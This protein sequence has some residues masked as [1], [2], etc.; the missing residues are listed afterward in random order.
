MTYATDELN[1]LFSELETPDIDAIALPSS[2]LQEAAN[3]SAQVTERSQQWQAYLNALAL[4]G[5]EAWLEERASDVQLDRADASIFAPTQAGAIA[6]TLGITVNQ[7]RVCLIPIDSEPSNF[8]SLDRII[9]ETAE[10]VPHFYVLVEINEEQEQV[11]ITGWLRADLLLARQSELRLG[12]DWKYDVPLAWFDDDCDNLLLYWRCASPSAIALP[13]PATETNRDRL[14]WLQLLAQ[15][16]INTAQWL[17]EEWQAIV[18]DLTWVLLPPVASTSG[19]RSSGISGAIPVPNNNRSPF[20]ELETILTA[21]ERTGIRLPS[22]A[23][24]AYQDFDLGEYPLRLYAVIGSEREND[25]AI[26]WSLLAILGKAT[27]RALPADLILRISDLTGVLVERQLEAQGA[28]LFAQVEG[29]PEERFLVTAS[30]A[31]GTERSLP[32][33]SFQAE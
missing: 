4:F 12:I 15:P 5:F 20:A 16:A 11:I 19:L 21:I 7:F 23:R 30:L 13:S 1:L 18:N 14:A 27:D 26:A 24:A 33:F 10:Y 2:S 3:L 25:G 28:Y 31:D 17:Q 8:V 9:I 32:P 29:T 22:N 6:A